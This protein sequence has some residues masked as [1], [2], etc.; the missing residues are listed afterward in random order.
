MSSGWCY[1]ATERLFSRVRGAVRPVAGCDPRGNRRGRRAA[2][3]WVSRA[4]IIERVLETRQ[5]MRG[6]AGRRS[7]PAIE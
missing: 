6:V 4:D 3:G 7:S 5:L 1:H 2:Q